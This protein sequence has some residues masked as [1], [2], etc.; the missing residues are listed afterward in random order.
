MSSSSSGARFPRNP[1]ERPIPCE[2]PPGDRESW[3]RL[4]VEGADN[5]RDLGGYRTGDGGR[6]RWGM[7]YRADGLHRLTDRDLRY[8]SRLRIRTVVDFREAYEYERAPD[9]L[10]D[11]ARAMQLPIAVGGADL[12]REIVAVLKGEGTRDL[13]EFLV[14]VGR[15][16]VRTHTAVYGEWL[17]NMAEN[18]GALPQVFH[19]S[20]GKDRTGFAAALLLRILGVPQET[21]V[22]DYELTNLHLHRLTRR[23]MRRV[24]LYSLFRKSG[25]PVRPMLLAEARYLQ[26]SFDA[27]AQDW[28]SFDRYVEE[29]LGLDAAARR[30]LR[31][32][33]VEPGQ[34]SF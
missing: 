18:E 23:I 33:L 28:G 9:R 27:I 8:L 13:S 11:G 16:L 30:R 14:E 17:R 1:A 12:R 15:E 19:C 7:V 34:T 22:E 32:M 21:V 4:P 20:A 2:L 3:R 31:D 5:F 26:A 6:L 24:R 25:E 10:P 29:G